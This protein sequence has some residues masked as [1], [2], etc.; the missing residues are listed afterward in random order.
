MKHEL[1][2]S[3]DERQGLAAYAA[4][5]RWPAG[6]TVYERHAPADGVFVVLSGSVVLRTRLKGGRAF[7]PRI[8]T[9]GH[10]FGVEGLA[11]AAVY[12]TDARAAVETQTLHLDG[13]RLRVLLRERPVEAQALLAQVGA[14]HAHLLDRLRELAALSVE[15]RLLA[16]VTR[17]RDAR[18]DVAPSDPVTFDAAGYRLL[19]EMVG[20]TRESVSLVVNRLVSEGLAERDGSNV[21]IRPPARPEDESA[22]ADLLLA[23][24]GAE[25]GLPAGRSMAS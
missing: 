12:R 15:Q 18:A 8:A 23:R 13:A 24:S 21:R 19:C 7:V 9:A 10:V 2:L 20:A 14:A 4:S 1:R 6:F 16:A 11:P 22:P 5:A 3:P 25:P 17:V